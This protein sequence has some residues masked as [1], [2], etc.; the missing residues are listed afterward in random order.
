MKGR[1]EYAVLKEQ[2]Q[3]SSTVLLP[4]YIP[5]HLLSNIIENIAGLMQCKKTKD[6]KKHVFYNSLEILNNC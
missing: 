3:T 6:E 2:H 4:T 5:F 1:R